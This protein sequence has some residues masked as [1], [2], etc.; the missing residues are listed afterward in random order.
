M[1]FVLTRLDATHNRRGFDC[2]EPALDC[3][4]RERAGQEARKGF[5]TIIVA[6]PK[7]EPQRVAGYYAIAA[8]SLPFA[9]LPENI[10][11]KLPR[12]PD[13][14]ALLL[15]RLAVDTHFQGQHLGA[16]LLFD[17]MHRALASELAWAFF[18]VHAKHKRAEQFYAKFL[19]RPFL[20][21]SAH[22]WLART[23]IVSLCRG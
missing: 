9:R 20:D 23:Q 22:L 11:H 18:L 14:P 12:Y 19:F 8:T 13:V 3:Y 2:G 4:L 1:T 21:N 15:G 10:T 7:K 16:Y 6:T 17:A 5:A